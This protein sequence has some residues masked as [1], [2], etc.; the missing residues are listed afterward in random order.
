MSKLISKNDFRDNC[1]FGL[2]ANIN[3]KKSHK[4]ITKSVDALK[5]MTHRGAIGADGKTGDGCGLLLDLDKKFFIDILFKEQDIKIT[6]EFAIAQVFTS[7]QIEVDIPKI[8]KILKSENLKLSAL[9]LVPTN[10][11]ILGSIAKNCLPNIYQLFIQSTDKVFYEEKFET[12]LYQ[13][14][15]LIEEIHSNDE[16]F[17][18]CSFS[19]KTIVYKGLMLPDA[20]K[21]FYLDLKSKNMKSSICVFH[22]RFS[23]NT[24]PRWHLAQPFRLLAHNGEINAIRGNRNWVKAR[25]SKFKSPRLP[26]IQKF[27][28]LVNES[29]SDSSALDNMIEILLK[30]GVKLFRAIRMLCLRL[31]KTLI[32][33]ILILEV[34][35]S[36]TPCT[37][38]LGMDLQELLCRM[39]N[40][41]SVCLT[42]MD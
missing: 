19:S 42:G 27:K 24:H 40:G 41:Q 11:H 7:K 37:W 23:T 1:G 20:I 13:A 14:R 35:M 12:N 5:S 22:Q 38:S 18:F 9:R 3:G 8:K 6:D 15:K 30:G 21:D 29:G 39:E 10:K 16:Q 25:S 2:I 31:G 36:I 4:I 17:Y 26:K 33:L 28:E 34:F 32:C